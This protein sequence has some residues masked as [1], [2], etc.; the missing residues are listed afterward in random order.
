MAPT[1]N[2]VAELQ[3]LYGPFTMA[4]RVVQKI[5]L[6]GDFNLS[7][8]RLS[9]GQPMVI[10]TAGAWN[11][12]AG[13][14]FLGARLVLGGREVNGDIEVHF[15]AADWRVHGHAADRAYANVVL[16]VVMFPPAPDEEPARH[17][18]GR[19][20]P[21]LVL[22]PLLHRDLEEYASDDA[23][24]V[25]TARDQ[26]EGFAELAALPLAERQDLIRQHALDRWNQK[27]HFA[28]LRIAKLGWTAALHQTSL[29]IL[30]YRHNRAAM[31]AVA[32]Q[33]PLEAWNG[34]FRPEDVFE[35][36]RSRWHGQGLRPANQPLN[37]LRQYQRWAVAQPNWPQRLPEFIADTPP[38]AGQVKIP[39]RR[40]RQRLGLKAQRERLARDLLV[41]AI[42]G[43][44][45]DNL[46]ADGFLPLLAART[47]SEFLPTWYHGFLGDIPAQL[48][49]ALPR[50]GLVDGRDWPYCQGC[51][52]GLLGWI[53]ERQ[54][55][56]SG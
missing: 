13:P 52:Q 14:D 2:H 10:R 22:L 4:E 48:R 42:G 1:I 24:E 8:A 6:R 26:W 12:Q 47:G 11:L 15:H 20:I 34:A 53:L 9:D 5:W 45:M 7:Q 39:T 31:L 40:A 21:L 18:D 54:A 23:L 51:A 35:E 19:V 36:F 16:H 38:F 44:R 37:R 30:G 3:G 27:V 56:A 17:A 41:D 25:I 43:T 32:A 50:L 49:R 28:R 33:Y 29:E 46:L 55:R